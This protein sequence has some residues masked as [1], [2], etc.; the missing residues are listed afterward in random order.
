LINQ[1]III[2]YYLGIPPERLTRLY[3]RENGKSG[4]VS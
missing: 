1:L 3:R 2:A 4:N